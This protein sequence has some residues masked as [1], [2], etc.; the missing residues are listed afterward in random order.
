MFTGIFAAGNAEAK[1]EVK[2][3]EELV[4]KVVPLDHAEVVDRLV[5]HCE[6]HPELREVGLREASMP[7]SQPAKGLGSRQTTTERLWK[8]CSHPRTPHPPAQ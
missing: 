1:V 7:T 2:A 6:L 4:S 8:V 5:A 3:F